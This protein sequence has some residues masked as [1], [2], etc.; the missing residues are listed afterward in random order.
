VLHERDA[1]TLAR[2][3][4]RQRPMLLLGVLLLVLGAGYM[5]WGVQRLQRTPAAA[6]VAAFDRPVAGMARLTADAQARLER[7]TPVTPLERSLLDDLRRQTDVTGRLLVLVLRV[8]L[9]SIV[10]TAGLVLL[11]NALALW[12]VLGIFRRLGV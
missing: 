6:E 1:Q 11:G 12:P 2:M 9:G 5:V 8:L 7:V 10:A 4:R 3:R